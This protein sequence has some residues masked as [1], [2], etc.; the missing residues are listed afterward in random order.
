MSAPTPSNELMD[1]LQPI[2]DWFQERTNLAERLDS[3]DTKLGGLVALA[4]DLQTLL[5]TLQTDVENL[6]SGQQSDQ[7]TITSLQSQLA[8]AQAAVDAAQQ[9]QSDAEAAQATAEATA[10][11]DDA[12]VAAVTQQ[13]TDAQ[14]QLQAAQDAVTALQAVVTDLG[15]Q[16][17]AFNPVTPPPAPTPPPPT[18]PAISG[19]D[20]DSVSDLGGA[21]VN[22]TGSGFTGATAVNFVDGSGNSTPATSFT[23]TDDS[24][25]SADTPALADGAYT[26]VVVASD[27]TTT[28]A[29]TPLTVGPPPA[30]APTPPAPTP[31]PPSATVTSVSPNNGTDAGGDSVAVTGSGFA[32]I[33]GVNFVDS[34]GN[35]TSAASYTLQD[36]ANLS[37]VT[38]ALADGTYDV[39]VVN[40]DG[41]TSATS[42]AD[43]FT[44][45][46]AAAP[47]DTPPAPPDQPP[48]PAP[49]N[50]TPVP[51][52]PNQAPV[53]AGTLPPD[54]AVVEVPAGMVPVVVPT[55]AVATTAGA[56]PPDAT[57]TPVQAP[58]GGS[59]Q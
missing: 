16:I 38:P 53:P 30:P 31:G 49:S 39:V 18:P 8:D 43:Q 14:T 2:L 12:Q 11:A 4:D 58:G 3:I 15:N 26:V 59:S 25:L 27:G 19:T 10:T 44:S 35:S 50:G 9:A 47:P 24:T 45:N 13:L 46:A 34:S 32:N 17:A 56:L 28:S 22:L 29:G 54:T 1:L 55:G 20:V 48:A 57:V 5:T 21:T 6:A 7:A 41:S 36:D 42:T 23:V 40:A 52:D 37:A 33:T 51:V